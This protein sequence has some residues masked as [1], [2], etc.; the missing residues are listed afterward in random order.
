MELTETG[1]VLR[2]KTPINDTRNLKEWI[3]IDIQAPCRDLVSTR[4]V[5][6]P[7]IY[8]LLPNETK[9]SAISRWIYI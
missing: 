7:L 6:T 3:E 4:G 5:D 1:T 8:V 2:R 9:F